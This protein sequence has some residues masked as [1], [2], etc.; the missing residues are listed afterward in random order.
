MGKNKCNKQWRGGGTIVTAYSLGVDGLKG[1]IFD[2]I[3]HNDTARFNKTHEEHSNYVLRS[4][5]KGGMDVAKTVR[6]LEPVAVT[7]TAP[8]TANEALTGLVKK[9]WMDGYCTQVR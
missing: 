4:L 7:P 5:E 6:T 9:I 8:S 3:G 2:C 1:H